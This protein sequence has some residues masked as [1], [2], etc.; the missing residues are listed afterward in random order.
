MVFQKFFVIFSTGLSEAGHQ[1]FVTV[2]VSHSGGQYGICAVV[3]GT[4]SGIKHG[5]WPW[6]KDYRTARVFE[7]GSVHVIMLW[8]RL[9]RGV[10]AAAGKV[11]GVDL[12]DSLICPGT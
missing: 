7:A 11:Y 3:G 12:V 10:S 5:A 4:D 2:L 8:S 6:D 1:L 9:S